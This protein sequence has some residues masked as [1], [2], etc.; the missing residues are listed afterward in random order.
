MMLLYTAPTIE[1]GKMMS[2]TAINPVSP[3]NPVGR[4]RRGQRT[5]WIGLCVATALIAACSS[6]GG[7]AG[8][9]TTGIT[10]GTTDGAAVSTGVTTEAEPA[11]T[12]SSTPAA[13]EPIVAE[14]DAECG[15][16][17]SGEPIRVGH[18]SSL[19]GPINIPSAGYAAEVA[20]EQYNTCGGFNGQ[21][22]ELVTLDGGLDPGTSA[23][24]ARELVEQDD[25][26]GFVGNNAF[27]D[28]LNGQ[29][30]VDNAVANIGSSYDDTCFQSEA[31]FPTLANFDRNIF[32]GI[33]YALDQGKTSF[34]YL[35]LD[36]PGQRA[37]SEALRTYL[38]SEGAELTT[39]I[40][41]PFGST[42]ANAA[43][44]TIRADDVD[45][46]VMSVDEV[47]FGAAAATAVQQGVGPDTKMWIAPS[48]IYSAKAV[49]A[50]G[51]AGNG[52]LVV[53]NYD[54]VENGNELAAELSDAI[55]ENHPDT[56][57]DGF[58]QLGWIA[59]ETFL[60]A[61]DSIDGEL[62][63][64]SL[65]AAMNDLGP[66]DSEFLPEP[67]VANSALPRNLVSQGL[68]LQLQDGEYSVVS[69][70]FILYPEP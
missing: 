42:D 5:A 17:A 58:A 63:R 7:A 51:P 70:G 13:T 30:Y 32:P 24:A 64:E 12:D 9:D 21:P 69:D 11:S 28:C 38:E 54:V 68:V 52:V 20:F 27:L 49:A 37:Q 18:I 23:A 67:V 46:V 25:V 8:D 65:L 53:A 34:A 57:V 36:I 14:P 50:I 55:V 45:A 43:I 31:I 48:G 1:E 44:Q 61:L 26:V 3:V 10:T 16:P 2:T 59:A 41:V 19:S 4:N 40:F 15:A 62:T 66:V 60:A 39:E 6:D 35:A 22:L 47:L 56:L 33:R 29:Y